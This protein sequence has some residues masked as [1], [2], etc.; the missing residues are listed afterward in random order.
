MKA[1]DYLK[2]DGSNPLNVGFII[3]ES[4]KEIIVGFSGTKSI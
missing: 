3:D 4:H 2:I 1:S